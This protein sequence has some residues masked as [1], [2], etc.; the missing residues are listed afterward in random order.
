M[1]QLSWAGSILLPEMSI[2]VSSLYA[3]EDKVVELF[4]GDIQELGK[5]FRKIEQEIKLSVL[6]TKEAE[7]FFN[8]VQKKKTIPFDYSKDGC[9]ARAH[10]MARI[11]QR[12]GI[13]V[14]KIF[15]DGSL[16]PFLNDG[17]SWRY[18]VAPVVAVKENKKIKLMVI[19]PSLFKRPVSVSD[20]SIKS[21]GSEK[22]SRFNLNLRTR[23][24][25]DLDDMW[26]RTKR[27]F[28]L[29]DLIHAGF[30][31]RKYRR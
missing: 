7:N 14:A 1:A 2:H 30:T 11:A 23:A 3:E 24:A 26:G 28:S 18:H 15:I 31:L 9:Y 16:D 10:R 27:S 25:Y 17:W 6:T 13:R 4:E 22:N 8:R 29:W 19:D 21:I 12:H 20:W 5:S